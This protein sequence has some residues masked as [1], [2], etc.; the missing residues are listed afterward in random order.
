[1]NG[2][3]EAGDIMR[4]RHWH[5]GALDGPRG[6]ALARHYSGQDRHGG[7]D[8]SDTG[9]IAAVYEHLRMDR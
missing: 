2:S 7:L 5:G 6:Q 4:K 3:K 9:G 1:M 8:G